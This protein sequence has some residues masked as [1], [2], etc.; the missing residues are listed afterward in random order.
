M[1]WSFLT[2]TE[3]PWASRSI[4]C[5]IRRAVLLSSFARSAAAGWFHLTCF[6]PG[7]LV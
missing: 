2:S 5:M 7:L 4:A 6:T 3:P 1:P